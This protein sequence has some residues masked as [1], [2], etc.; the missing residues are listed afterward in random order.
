MFA[1]AQQALQATMIDGSKQP[2][3]IPDEVAWRMLLLSTEE[4]GTS[5]IRSIA[6]QNAKLQQAGITGPDLNAIKPQ[7]NRFHSN[8]VAVDTALQDQSISAEL[9]VSLMQQR[10]ALFRDTQ[11]AMEKSLSKEGLKGLQEYI[12]TIKRNITIVLPGN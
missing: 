1:N 5:P 11:M 3:L 7:L 2:E 9:R 6:I 8:R 12:Q 10:E 4:S